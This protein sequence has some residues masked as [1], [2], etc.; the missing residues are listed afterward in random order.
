LSKQ[1]KDKE[2]P[3]LEGEVELP[4]KRSLV[5]HPLDTLSGLIAEATRVYRQVRDKKLDHAEGRSLVWILAQMRAMVE[6]QALER[7]EQ[8]L[9][10]LAPSIEGR[11]HGLTNTNRP[12]RPTH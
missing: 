6:T 2:A 5:R 4:A 3:P 1:P 12:H 10:E 11:G 9:E 8:R 7:L